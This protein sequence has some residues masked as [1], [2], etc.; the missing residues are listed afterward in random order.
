MR[1]TAFLAG[2]L[3]LVLLASV[4]STVTLVTQDDVSAALQ[5]AFVSNRLGNEDI[6]VMTQASDAGPVSNLTN[7]PARDWNPAWSPRGDQL[8]FN[9]DRDGRD[10]LYLMNADGT[11]ARPLFPGESFDDYDAAW[12]PDG[13]KIVF[14]S[15][16]AGAGRELYIADSPGDNI[17]ALTDDGTI[18]GDLVWSPDGQE[19]VYWEVQNNTGDI[20]LFRRN[21]E[22]EALLRLSNEGPDNGAAVWIGD[23]I[24]FDTN[25]LDDTWYI[26]SMDPEG[27]RPERISTEGVNS[28]RVTVAPDGSR[29]AFVTDRD[30]SDEIY[31]MNP[32]GTGLKR[33]TD[34]GYSDHS[35]AWQPALP[36]D[37]VVEAVQ[38][39]PE[40]TEEAVAGLLGPA[41][42]LSTNGIVAHPISMQQ[43]LIDYGIAAW[44]E[45]GW[46]GAGQRIGVIDTAFGGLD[47][48]TQDNVEVHLPRDADGG[49]YSD[50]NS[51]HGVRV[52]EIIHTIAPD[53]EQLREDTISM[54][55]QGM[56][57]HK[58]GAAPGIHWTRVGQIIITLV[59]VLQL[60]AKM[61]ST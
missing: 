13:S 43:L 19:I 21:I 34:N 17:Q 15:D 57:Y 28:G 55:Q 12:S 8:I 1:K 14:V 24:Y 32:D 30:S 58:I 38:P 29:L 46:T 50:D 7:N 53:K 39:T 9:S 2:L 27:N 26:F 31:V 44:H 40:P 54:R 37:Q 16:R 45:A 48:F 3:G 52:L 49:I 6:Y 33:L 20:H 23:T 41:V 5:I 61:A 42:G 4:S 22:T 35:P 51:D 36:P 59:V 25:R 10:T 56:S 60:T 47:D 11:N 18:K